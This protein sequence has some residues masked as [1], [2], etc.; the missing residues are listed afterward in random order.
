M[1][2]FEIDATFKHKPTKIRISPKWPVHALSEQDAKENFEELVQKTY[3][4]GNISG[5]KYKSVREVHE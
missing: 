3:G 1:A 2:L 4:A 5:I